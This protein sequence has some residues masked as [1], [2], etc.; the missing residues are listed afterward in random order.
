MYKYTKENSVAKD[1]SQDCM[2]SNPP[3]RT[4]CHFKSLIFPVCGTVEEIQKVYNLIIAKKMSLPR[5]ESSDLSRSKNMTTLHSPLDQEILNMLLLTLYKSKTVLSF[6]SYRCN[7]IVFVKMRLNQV[8]CLDFA[9]GSFILAQKQ[10]N[11]TGR[12]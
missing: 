11:A 12:S 8:Q 1:V 9:D 3:S 7:G 10:Y 5:F 4:L 6:N 2:H